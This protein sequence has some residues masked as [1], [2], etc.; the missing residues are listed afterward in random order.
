LRESASL[1]GQTAS[2]R[3]FPTCDD[4]R[5][6]PWRREPPCPAR[7]RRDLIDCSA[8]LWRGR[9]RPGAAEQDANRRI[10]G[11]STPAAAGPWVAAFA[12]RLREAGLDRGT[13]RRDRVSLGGGRNERM[14][15]ICGRVR[16]GQGRCHCCTRNPSSAGGE[17]CKPPLSQSS[18]AL[19]GGP[20]GSGLVASLA[21]PGRNVTGLSSQ[22]AELGGK[23]LD[24]L[25]EIVPGL[26]RLAIMAN[27]GNAANVIGH[28][29]G[30]GGGAGQRSR[31]RQL[32]NPA[33][34][35][36]CPRLCWRSKVRLMQLYVSA[37]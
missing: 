23:R 31:G 9:S 22:T 25:R 33:N 37:R 7:G 26:R 34:R 11:A 32:R 15:E 12:Q 8:R 19:P 30:S 3:R 28:A 21:R 24:L 17:E 1:R 10:P 14:A 6:A 27:V 35:G 20:V 18:S 5:A 36:Y 16:A 2:A 13:H 29:R 4:R